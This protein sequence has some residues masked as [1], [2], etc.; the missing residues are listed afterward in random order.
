MLLLILNSGHSSDRD[1]WRLAVVTIDTALRGV[2]S[3]AIGIGTLILVEVWYRNILLLLARCKS[4]L[5]AGALRSIQAFP[6]RVL[7]LVRGE[8][9]DII[10][11][12]E[13]VVLSRGFHSLNLDSAFAWRWSKRAI[14]SLLCAWLLGV[15]ALLLLKDSPCHLGQIGCI[16]A[17]MPAHLLLLLHMHD[18]ITAHID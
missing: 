18:M 2:M 14:C 15:G 4:L 6:P 10:N 7:I 12:H 11:Q 3:L 8:L 17:R 1:Q 9:I 13:R 16:C 5:N